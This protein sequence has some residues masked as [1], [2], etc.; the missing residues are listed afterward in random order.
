MFDRVVQTV[1]LFQMGNSFGADG[2]LIASDSTFFNL[3]S[4]RNP[5]QV[6]I[7]LIY[8]S[9]DADIEIVQAQLRAGLPNDIKVLT[10]PESVGWGDRKYITLSYTHK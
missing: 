3:F 1:G 5:T 8:L 2:N 6:D 10:M 4:D 9:E 7:G